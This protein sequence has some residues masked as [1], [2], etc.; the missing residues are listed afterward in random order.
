MMGAGRIKASIQSPW[1]SHEE[2]SAKHHEI[3]VCT[4]IFPRH[5]AETIER[6]KEEWYVLLSIWLPLK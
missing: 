3:F 6:F 4:P 5:L 1:F 2:M